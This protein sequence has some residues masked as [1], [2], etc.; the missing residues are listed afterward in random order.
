MNFNEFK[1]QLKHYFKQQVNEATFIMFNRYKNFLIAE[2]KKM[3]LTNLASEELIYEEYFLNSLIP[4]INLDLNT[5]KLLDIGS[6]S[7]IPGIVLKI[8]F[9]KMHLTILEANTKKIKFM[10][11]LANLLKFDD[12]IF[13]NQRAEEIKMDQ[14]DKFDIVT[15]RA[16]ANLAILVEIS[17]AYL[18]P[19]G[20]LIEPKSI[21]YQAEYTQIK[22][23]LERYGLVL[24]KINN[25]LTTNNKTINT[26][27]FIKAKKPSQKLPRS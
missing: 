10:Q 3:N 24:E 16:V 20:L 13:F 11:E 14:L 26:F 1:Q 27:F 23:H 2:N 8:I 5:I 18:K 21:N 9:P 4:F 22:P 12:I 7:G 15:S 25:H 17:Y 6:G 19:N